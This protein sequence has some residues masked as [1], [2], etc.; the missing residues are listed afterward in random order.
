MYNRKANKDK[1]VYEVTINGKTWDK[2][3]I[4]NLLM[5]NDKAVYKALLLLC[6][7][8]TDE[9]KYLGTAKT[10]NRKGFNKL[11]A[12]TLTGFAKQI[13]SGKHLTERQLQTA[14][15]KLLKYANQILKYMK[16]KEEAKVTLN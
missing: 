12:F 7:F 5:T 6:S 16:E 15:Y 9:E 2:E 1:K 13:K 11:D 8:Q 3:S 10:Y 4:K 14:R